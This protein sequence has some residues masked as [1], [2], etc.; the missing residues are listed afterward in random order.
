VLKYA[1]TKLSSALNLTYAGQFPPE[2][3][4]I[5][6]LGWQLDSQISWKYRVSYF[7]RQI[8]FC[9]FYN[10]MTKLHVDY[11]FPEAYIFCSFLF[12]N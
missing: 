2:V 5:K 10:E 8:E 12:S 1:P 4:T 11:W 6:F 3:E 9:L 7:T